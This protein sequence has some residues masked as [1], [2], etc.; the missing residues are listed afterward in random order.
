MIHSQLTPNINT[1]PTR[2]EP[3]Y[4]LRGDFHSNDT[5]RVVRKTKPSRNLTYITV[6]P[7]QSSG[8]EQLRHASSILNE[9]EVTIFTNIIRVFET[10]FKLFFTRAEGCFQNVQST[11][12]ETLNLM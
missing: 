9:T 3:P 11:H 5:A 2:T 8:L 7:I 1:A 4:T 12:H 10:H 6:S